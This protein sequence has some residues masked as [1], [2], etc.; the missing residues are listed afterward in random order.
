MP[1][2]SASIASCNFS[3]DGSYIHYSIPGGGPDSAS[4]SFDTQLDEEMN[5]CNYFS[6]HPTCY[7]FSALT[8]LLE[9]SSKH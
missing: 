6:L 4:S 7:L 9:I 8:L 3:Q 1:R 2:S 5:H